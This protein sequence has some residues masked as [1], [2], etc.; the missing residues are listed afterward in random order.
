MKERM[1]RKPFLGGMVAGLG[2]GLTI[3]F[4]LSSKYEIPIGIEFFVVG[5]LLMTL[6]GR[7]GRPRLSLSDIATE[8]EDT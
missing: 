7:I 8:E 4:L 6:G 5:I 1:N 3:A 2:L